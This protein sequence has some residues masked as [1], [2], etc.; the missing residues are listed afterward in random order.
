[1]RFSDIDNH[2]ARWRTASALS[3]PAQAGIRVRRGPSIQP[4]P[5]R[6][7]GSPVGSRAMTPRMGERRANNMQSCRSPRLP[8][9]MRPRQR[10]RAAELRRSQINNVGNGIAGNTPASGNE[11]VGEHVRTR[12]QMSP[13]A[14]C[15]IAEPF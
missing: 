7:T 14:A 3:F 8:R 13:R 12:F 1:M 15:G 11:G 10:D 4:R 2:R 6:R 5:S 9:Q